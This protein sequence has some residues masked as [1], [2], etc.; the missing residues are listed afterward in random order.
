[1]RVGQVFNVIKQMGAGWAAN[2]A[3]YAI[4]RKL[5]WFERKFPLCDWRAYRLEKIANDLSADQLMTFLREDACQRFFI[6]PAKRPDYRKRL[7]EM[8]S[9]RAA[10]DLLHEADAVQQGKIRFFSGDLLDAGW[11]I[12]WHRHLETNE[13][14]P[15]VHWS[16][17][18]DFGNSDVKWL[19]ETGRFGFAYTLVRAYWLTGDQQQAETFWQI[20]ENFKKENPPNSG[21]HWMCGQECS[22]RVFACCFALFGLLDAAATTAE[23]VTLLV[24]MLAAHGDR[25]EGNIGYAISQKNNHAITE[26][27]A[28]WTLGLLFPFFRSAARWQILGRKVLEQE[29][30]R[31]IYDDGAY[32]Q[33]SMNYHRLM[34]QSFVWAIRLG[35]LNGQPLSAT[36][37]ERFAKAAQFLYQLTDEESGRAPNYGSND[38][39]VLFRLDSCGFE[40]YRPTLGLAHWIAERGRVFTSG[41][42]EEPLLWM[43]GTQALAAPTNAPPRADLAAQSGGYYT[44]RGKETWAMIRCCEYRDRPAQADMLHLDLWWRGENIVADPGTYSYNS[45]PPWNNGLAAT[46]A[47]NTVEIDGLD[48]MERGPRFTWFHWNRGRVIRHWMDETGRVKGFEGEH[49][50]Y[51]RRLGVSHRRSLILFDDCVLIVTDE[52]KGEGI[53][54]LASQWLFPKAE[55]A[56]PLDNSFRILSQPHEFLL[57]VFTFGS[58]GD[59][60]SPCVKPIISSL[61]SSYGWL[62][63]RY[64][65][66]ESVAALLRRERVRLPVRW[67]TVI[68]FDREAQINMAEDGGLSVVKD[69]GSLQVSWR[70][71]AQANDESSITGITIL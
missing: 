2:R 56:E 4:K 18:T 58:A 43:A 66:K 67:Q 51:W 65:H 40:D 69:R 23:R 33:H 26:A 12:D 30:G 42:W 27:L 57:K 59:K 64:L 13:R 60:T 62:S 14:W 7:S 39:A 70:D 19:W 6:Q 38:G 63:K 45:A 21:A 1:M 36:L 31:Q 37:R 71:F 29:A 24:E 17:L 52:V 68:S 25:I 35:E 15:P 5:G 49:D 50:G 46:R 44:L 61:D 20:V 54:D 3:G 8:L 53:H 34:L 28:L 55:I 48:Q 47:H 22:I 10:T 41:A 11:P 16:R 32:V 9:Y